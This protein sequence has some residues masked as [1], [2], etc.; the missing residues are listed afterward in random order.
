[1]LRSV[2]RVFSIAPGFDPAH[3]LTLQVQTSGHRFHDDDFTHRY[4]AQ[5]LDA[6]RQVPGVTAAAFTTQLPLS[7]DFDVYGAKLEPDSQTPADQFGVLRYAVSPGYLEAMRISLL[8]GRTFL[9]SDRANS[10]RVAIVSESF[11]RRELQ[12]RDPIGHRMHLASLE[13]WYTIVGVVQDVKQTSLAIKQLDAVYVPS[14]QWGWAD[15]TR[16]LVVRER[17]DSPASAAAI[18]NAIWSVDKDQ[19]IVRIATM[20]SL[21]TASEAERHFVLTLFAVFAFAALVLAAV[22]IYGIL[23][24]SVTER[25]LEIGVR[26]AL[27]ASRTSILT[28][29]LRQGMVLTGI[30]IALGVIGAGIASRALI[31]LLFGTSPLDPVTYFRVVGLLAAVSL[32]ACGIPAWRAAHVDPAIALRSE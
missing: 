6:V 17:S 8:H 13:A 19:P 22:G 29:V 21:I 14:E 23:S 12:G 16:S 9:E 2:Q 1:M 10:P 26:S 24:G 32:L 30:G 25:T 28:M 15:P 11:V 3:V 7:G 18:R 27:G 31:T 5:V 4:F 20:D